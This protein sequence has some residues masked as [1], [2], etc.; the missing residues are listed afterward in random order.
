[1][2][3]YAEEFRG[4]IREFHSATRAFYE[5]ELSVAEYKHISGGFGSYAQRGGKRSMLRLRLS[6]GIVTKD[7][8]RFIVESIEKY[9]IDL[10]HISTCQTIQLHNLTAD[11]VCSLAEESLEHGIITR[12]GGGDFPRNVMMSPLSGVSPDETFD[13]SGYACAAADYL[14]GFIHKVKLPRKLKVCFSNT[15]EDITH[16]AFRDLGFVAKENHTFDVYSAGGLG[17]NPK[18]G[19]CVAKDVPPELV[20][21]YIRAMVDTFTSYGNYES[22]AKAR[23][24]Y[25]QDTLGP[26]KYRAAFLEK[27]DRALASK[28]LKLSVTPYSSDKPKDGELSHPRAIL[29]KQPGLYAVSYHPIGGCLSSDA[30]R[31]IYQAI[32][33]MKD[34]QLRLSPDEGMYII[35]CTAKE[36]ETLIELT[37]DG[38]GTL[39][40]TSVACIGSQ[41]CQLGLRDSQSL[42]KACTNAVRS[43]HFDDGTL[44]K[45][46]ISGCPSSCGSHQ[47]AEL[48]FRGAVKQS[49]DGPKP[50]Y[51]LFFGGSEAL[52]NERLGT[53]LCVMREE[54]IPKFLVALGS[55]VQDSHM[56]FSGW[57]QTNYDVFSELA[58]VYAQ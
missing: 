9:G 4:D 34:V 22:R 47:A 28:D 30:L 16:A 6:G 8:L 18:M 7:D 52:G 26:E 19:V 49:P 32:L 39:F 57:I 33:P 53:E 15:P 10:L 29:Q 50:A 13:V 23:T 37:K 5:K 12:G 24:R 36:A 51:A 3:N 42:L 54:N 58:Q 56:T 46:H 35:N 43:C 25:M 41:I 17:I 2:K 11:A 27:L 20:L 21:Y 44:P 48:G 40:E 1:M 45:I 55:R 14:L 38:A 31:N